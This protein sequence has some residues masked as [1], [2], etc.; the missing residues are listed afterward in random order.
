MN[1]YSDIGGLLQFALNQLITEGELMVSVR[2]NHIEDH[3]VEVGSRSRSGLGINTDDVHATYLDLMFLHNK[4][5][6]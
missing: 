2:S 3:E 5:S 4:S 1:M 6:I